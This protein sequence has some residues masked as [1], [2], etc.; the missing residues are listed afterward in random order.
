ML[1]LKHDLDLRMIDYL[2]TMAAPG[3]K[4]NIE[5]IARKL[6]ELEEKMGST[7]AKIDKM[8][9][10]IDKGCPCK[11]CKVVVIIS[12]PSS[13]LSGSTNK[14]HVSDTPSTTK[15]RRL[16]EGRIHGSP[17]STTEAKD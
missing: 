17:P 16:E 6:L 5:W 8:Q 9:A 14:S 2:H 13:I 7:D 12:S 15:T 11:N 3:Q 1:W 10:K 4:Y